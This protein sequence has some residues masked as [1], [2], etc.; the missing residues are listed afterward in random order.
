M[1]NNN[2]TVTQRS[3][4]EACY[5]MKVEPSASVQMHSHNYKVEVTVS[6]NQQ[7]TDNGFIIEFSRLKHLLD[8]VLPDHKLILYPSYNTTIY[9]INKKFEYF[10]QGLSIVFNLDKEPTAENLIT[11]IVSKL[12]D[13]LDTQYPGV[14]IVNAKLRETNDSFAEWT[15]A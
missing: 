6:G 8:S 3:S 15:K 2:V 1:I 4:F 12:Q 10:T 14:T 9:D 7:M 13:K 5:L 11:Y